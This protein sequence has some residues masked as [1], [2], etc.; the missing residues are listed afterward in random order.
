MDA[1]QLQHMMVSYEEL[2]LNTSE[3]LQRIWTFLGLREPTRAVGQDHSRSHILR[4]NR[5]R[6]QE[7]KRSGVSY[8]HR[9]FSRREWIAPSLAFPNIMRRN[10]VLLYLNTVTPRRGDD[11]LL[12][13]MRPG[14]RVVSGAATNHA[15]AE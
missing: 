9:W 10:R 4:G 14:R 1:L 12:D 3:V 13:L 7:E 2:C 5:M 8:D 11:E 6:F 15:G